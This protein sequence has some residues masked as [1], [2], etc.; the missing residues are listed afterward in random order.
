[1]V[2]RRSNKVSATA[3]DDR[4]EIDAIEHGRPHLSGTK[5]HGFGPGR[6]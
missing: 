2:S 4:L 5:R 1:M 6:A 3:I